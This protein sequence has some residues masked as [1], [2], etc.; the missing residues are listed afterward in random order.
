MATKKEHFEEALANVKRG[1]RLHEWESAAVSLAWMSELYVNELQNEVERLTAALETQRALRVQ[2]EGLAERNAEDAALWRA[3]YNRTYGS[4]TNLWVNAD[5]TTTPVQPSTTASAETYWAA[6]ALRTLHGAGEWKMRAEE[7]E[8]ESARLASVVAKVEALA[9]GWAEAAADGR[10]NSTSAETVGMRH[11]WSEM[12]ENYYYFAR[13][14]RAA[15]SSES[16]DTT[17]GCVGKST[18]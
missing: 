1:H 8:A 2:A 12:A 7:A 5:G 18:R 10:R 9:D 13:P 3:H 17:G 6:V 14:V 16:P 15:L 4:T 11:S